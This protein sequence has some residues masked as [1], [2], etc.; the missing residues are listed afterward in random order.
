[1]T[2]SLS[3]RGE[4]W[5]KRTGP[6]PATSTTTLNGKEPTKA[7]APVPWRAGTHSWRG[8]AGAEAPVVIWRT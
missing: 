8:L 7:S 6:R 1:M 4:P 3:L 2:A 5:Q